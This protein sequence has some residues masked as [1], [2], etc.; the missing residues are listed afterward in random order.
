M[1]TVGLEG[2][3]LCMVFNGIRSPLDHWHFE[4]FNVG[5]SEDPSFED[6]KVTFDS[7]GDSWPTAVLVPFEPAV[8]P[9]EFRR[10]GSPC[11]DT[12]WL[13]ALDGDYLDGETVVTVTQRDG[14]PYLVWPGV[15]EGGLLAGVCGEATLAAAT[16]ATLRFLPAVSSDPARLLLFTAESVRVAIRIQ[17]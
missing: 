16:R 2:D 11:S 6:L 10:E 1:L 7:S 3:R 4:T 8:G 5:T 15:G 12:L 13:A 17:P 9:I 14:G